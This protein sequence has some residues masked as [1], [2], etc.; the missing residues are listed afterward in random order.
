MNII[1]SQSWLPFQRIAVISYN[2]GQCQSL[3]LS[4]RA[5]A[6]SIDNTHN[7]WLASHS[8]ILQAHAY[9]IGYNVCACTG[10]LAVGRQY[11]LVPSL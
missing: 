7:N 4:G 5:L 10:S 8:R 11:I 6:V 1:I 3:W 9:N 2:T